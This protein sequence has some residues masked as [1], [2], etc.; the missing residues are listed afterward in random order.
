MLDFKTYIVNTLIND[1]VLQ[2]YLKDANGNMNVFPIDVDIQPEQ[3]P[4]IVYQDASISEL[5]IPRGMHVGSFQIDILSVHN[6]LKVEM[7]YEQVAIL[8]NFKDSTTQTIPNNGVLWW[9][10]EASVRDLHESQRRLWRKII[11]Y[12]VWFSKGNNT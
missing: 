6:E 12:R 1:P 9:M 8:L 4:C 11:T 2:T 3:F 10:R 7:I 5:S